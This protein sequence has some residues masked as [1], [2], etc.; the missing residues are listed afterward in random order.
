[1][2]NTQIELNNEYLYIIAVS[3]SEYFIQNLHWKLGQQSAICWNSL[4]QCRYYG[5]NHIYFRNKTF[6]FQDRKLKLSTSVCKRFS[7]NFTKFQFIQLIQTIFISIFCIRCLI[8]LIFCDVSRFIFFKQ[9]LKV[10]AFNLEK[11]KSF[12]PKTYII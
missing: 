3:S 12:I 7:S 1:M 4:G 5:L 9:M 6:F 2:P 11:Q 10:L 8:E